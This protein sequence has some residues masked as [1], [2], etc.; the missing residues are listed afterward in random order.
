MLRQRMR[1]IAV[2]NNI[3]LTSRIVSYVMTNGNDDMTDA[4]IL[5]LLQNATS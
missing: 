1:D 4:E 5:T 2:E 3:R